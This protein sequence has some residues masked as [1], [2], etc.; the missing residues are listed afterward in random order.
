M[1]P[2]I[3]SKVIPPRHIPSMLEFRET[4]RRARRSMSDSL[5]PSG[6]ALAPIGEKSDEFGELQ[7]W[8][9]RP[10]GLR[11]ARR[12]L[13]LRECAPLPG[14]RSGPPRCRPPSRPSRRSACGQSP[15][16]A[17][18]AAAFLFREMA[19]RVDPGHR[20]PGSIGCPLLAFI[21]CGHRITDDALNCASWRSISI[22]D[23]GSE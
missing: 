7:L 12:R 8:P 17:E 23:S 16:P 2:E 5:A 11:R 4:S 18:L 21:E 9:C 1:A 15:T 13:R 22:I 6:S 3:G 10:R 20:S 19:A 14:R